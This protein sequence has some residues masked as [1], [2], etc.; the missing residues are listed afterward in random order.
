MEFEAIFK[1]KCCKDD[2]SIKCVGN[3]KILFYTGH[4]M[5]YCNVESKDFRLH[6]NRFESR[7]R[8]SIVTGIINDQTSLCKIA[9][10]TNGKIK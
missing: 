8:I 3:E 2:E 6:Y 7:N 1:L 5:S 9:E 10:N 4:T